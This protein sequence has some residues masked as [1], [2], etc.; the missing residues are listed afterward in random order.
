MWKWTPNSNA[1]TAVN[2]LPPNAV[3]NPQPQ[4]VFYYHFNS[5][6][7]VFF[8]NL[9]YISI[10]K[11]KKKQ[12]QSYHFSFLWS[13]P[14]FSYFL[15]FL[16]GGERGKPKELWKNFFLILKGILNTQVFCRFLF[17]IIN[18]RNVSWRSANVSFVIHLFVV[19]FS[20]L[21]NF[22]NSKKIL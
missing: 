3:Y 8:S 21:N 22:L 12:N 5:W 11:E 15:V 16:E 20:V 7:T 2:T 18:L 19:I 14:S 1:S 6:H 9:N 4:I 17:F 13:T 10:L